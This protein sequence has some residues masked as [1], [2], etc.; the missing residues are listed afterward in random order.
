MGSI[1]DWY[2]CLIWKSSDSQ[3]FWWEIYIITIKE[4]VEKSKKIRKKRRKEKLI[5]F[6]THGHI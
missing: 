2:L 1:I 3:T 5:V 6:V 4:G